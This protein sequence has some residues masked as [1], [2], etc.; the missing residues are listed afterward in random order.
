[1]ELVS[2]GLL[3]AKRLSADSKRANR[4]EERRGYALGG[5]AGGATGSAEWNREGNEEVVSG[6]AGMVPQ[7]E[8]MPASAG[9]TEAQKS[10]IGHWGDGNP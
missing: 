3:A 6:S 1:M 8:R 9:A 4:T 7:P 2:A 10:A 5:G